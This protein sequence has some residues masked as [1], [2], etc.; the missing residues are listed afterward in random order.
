VK[1]VEAALEAGAP[2]EAVFVAAGGAEQ[3][4]VS[5]L[6]A[7]AM[8]QGIRLFELA[9]G[10][11]DRVADTVTPQPVC[12][13]VAV[14]DAPIESL[15]A[16]WR[17]AGGE[18]AREQPPSGGPTAGR[19]VLVCIDVRDPGNL[20][21]I[22]RSAGASGATAVVCC[23][24]SVDPYNP[25]AVRASAG[26]IFRLPIVRAGTEDVLFELS[27]GGF[28]L[29]GTSPAGGTDYLEADLAGDIAVLVG[30]EASGLPADLVAR[31]DATVTIPMAHAESLNV[32]MT[33]TILSFEAARRRRMRLE[34]RP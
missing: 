8:R 20:G 9:P 28:R 34:R 6:A 3:E 22:V 16:N 2:V 13:I 17:D 24:S 27:R 21:A 23:G 7:E 14:A 31:L 15:S 12:A 4:S 19:V 25:K 32:A 29:V 11:M 10:V 18:S 26:V 1:V 30:N 33:A 5:R